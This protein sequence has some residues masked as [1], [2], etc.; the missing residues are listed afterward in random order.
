MNWLN[1][2]APFSSILVI[3]N[4]D[5]SVCCFDGEGQHVFGNLINEDFKTVMKR[6][7]AKRVYKR[8]LELCSSCINSQKGMNFEEIKEI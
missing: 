6:M 8:S 7:P 3:D 2:L 5:G 4:G 1:I